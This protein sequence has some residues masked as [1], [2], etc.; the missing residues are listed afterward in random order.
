[1]NACLRNRTISPNARPFLYKTGGAPGGGDYNWSWCDTPPPSYLSKL[2]GGGS[3]GGGGVGGGMG[4]GIGSLAGGGG[5]L[6][7]THYYHMHT[8]RGC[9]GAWGYRGMYAIIAISC[10]CR[11]E[12]LKGLRTK[13]IVPLSTKHGTKFLALLAPWPPHRY[14]SKLGGGGGAGGVSHTRTGPGRPPGGGVMSRACVC[15]CSVQLTWL[16]MS[17]MLLGREGACGLGSGVT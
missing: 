11:E 15:V 13:G 9:L 17:C 16:L 4:G 3:W 5:G 10:L 2:A 8:S 1:M 6:R 12:S 7:T 14:Q